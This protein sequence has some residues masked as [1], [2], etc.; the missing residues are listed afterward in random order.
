MGQD[1]KL[2]VLFLGS[3]SKG[4]ATL[5]RHGRSCLLID[6]GFS[7]RE[8]QRRLSLVGASI[9]AL[10]AVLITHEHK[11]HVLGLPLLARREGFK[12]YS[13]AGTLEAAR[14]GPRARCQRL[15][16]QPGRPLRVKEI[17]VRP[18]A[19]SHDASDPVG[20]VL[21]FADGARL[22]IAT[23][24]GVARPGV[25]A[26]L[27]GCDY[28]GLESNHDVDMLINGPYPWFLKKRIQ[29]ARGHLCNEDT[30]ALLERVASPRLR[31][32]F[33]LHISE[34]NNLPALAIRALERC[35]RRIGRPVPVTA[36]AQDRPTPFRFSPLTDAPV[37][38]VARQIALF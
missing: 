32:V 1:T 12:V 28:L 22:G 25:V 29:S 27:K 33:A 17:E 30:A 26:A 14:F 11:D 15:E 34:N 8:L 7:G 23:D 16:L 18:F 36:V 21:R 2:E 19:T 6:C 10:D 31:Q 9:E 5:I 37:T 38:S 35:V 3:G 13:T 4:N 24:L 20:Y